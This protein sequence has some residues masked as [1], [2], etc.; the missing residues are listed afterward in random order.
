M[1]R[2]VLAIP[3]AA[4][5]LALGACSATNISP[6]P[7]TDT[8]TTT[9]T[10]NG[11]APTDTCPWDPTSEIG[12]T[13]CQQAHTDFQNSTVPSV[14]QPAADE[15]TLDLKTTSQHCFGSAGCNVEVEPNLGFNGDPAELDAWTCEVTYEIDGGDSP[16]IETAQQH[17]QQFSYSKSFLA[18]SS[19]SVNLAAKVTDVSCQ[20]GTG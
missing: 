14:P 12:S 20:L 1:K 7:T 16:V 19:S 3:L 6:Q 9:P 10:G 4:A 17:G 8:T 15:F 5:A 11:I 18:T 2:L 13:A